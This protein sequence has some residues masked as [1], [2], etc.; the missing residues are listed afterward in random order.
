M[1]PVFYFMT[2]YLV[3]SIYSLKIN[4]TAIRVDRKDAR[5]YLTLRYVVQT[6]LFPS[7]K[8]FKVPAWCEANLF[9]ILTILKISLKSAVPN[10]RGSIIYFEGGHGG[11]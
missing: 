9:L 1:T 5:K 10:E 2:L 6:R 4:T 3:S 7:E 8:H 11:L